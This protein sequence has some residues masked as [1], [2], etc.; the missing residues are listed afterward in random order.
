MSPIRSKNCTSLAI[1]K[2]HLPIESTITSISTDVMKEALPEAPPATATAAIRNAYARRVIEQQEVACLMLVS[3]T[4]EIPKNVE[5]YVAFEILLELKTMFQQQA[6]QE[7]FE[8]GGEEGGVLG[9]MQ[10]YNMHDMG[11]TIT[12]LR[13]M[14][15]LVEKGIPK[16]A[17][18]VLAIRQE[19]KKNKANTSST[20]GIF[21][22][23]LYSFPK[24]NSWIYDTGYGVEAIGS[25]DL[26]LPS[27]MVLVL[28]NCHFAPSITR[29]VISLSRL[30]DNGFLYKF[31]DYGVISVSK[32]NVFYF[33]VIPCD[34]IFEIDIHNC[35]SNERSIYTCSNKKSKHNLDSTFLWHC[36]LGHINKKRIAKLQHDGLLKSI[37]DESFDVCV[38]CISG[39]MTRK[40]F[41]HASKRVDDLLGLMHSDVCGPFRTTS[42]GGA[43]YYVT[44]TDGFSRYGYVHLI[45]HKHEVFEMFKTFQNE[46]EN[47]LG[48]TIKALRSNQGGEYLSKR[49]GP[50]NEYSVG[51]TPQPTLKHEDHANEVRMMREGFPNPLA[52]VANSYITPPYYNNPQPQYNT[53]SQYHQ[54]LSPVAQQFYSSHPPQQSYEAPV[55]HQP[56]HGPVIHSPPV[57]P[58]QAYQPL[59]I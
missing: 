38:S 15:K 3:M 7:L 18:A 53:Q 43:K 17:L 4:P 56:Y 27:G 52:L 13:A 25:F 30:W 1:G 2:R 39:K 10:N 11:N 45:K 42:R 23:E 22:I 50:T 14:L 21:T 37:D 36:H 26:I 12:E 29:G 57:V 51:Y 48:K 20:S 59:A 55:P 16:K 47:Q 40:P 28:D 35:V 9:F 41:T 24:T 32:D 6:E 46:V 54:Q 33:N 31:T 44:F 19:L 34:D 49:N 58:Q 5:D 8:T